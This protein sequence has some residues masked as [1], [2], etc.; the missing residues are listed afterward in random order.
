MKTFYRLLRIIRPYWKEI[1]YSVILGS[2]TIGSGIALI[3]TSSFLISMAAL[4][5]SIADLQIAIVGV[6]LF[7]ISRGVFRYAE[8]LVS[9][10]VNFKILAELRVNFFKA[11]IPLLTSKRSTSCSNSIQAIQN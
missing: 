5:T 11:L 6:R 10:S 8:R 1:T 7:G 2:L 4:H 3:G 9:H